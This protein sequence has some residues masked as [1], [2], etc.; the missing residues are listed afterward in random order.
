MSD[1][2]LPNENSDYSLPGRADESDAAYFVSPVETKPKSRIL[3]LAVVAFILVSAGVFSYYFVNQNEINS[4]IMDNTSFKTAEQ[5]MAIKYNVGQLGSN[6]A[7]AAIAVFV[8]GDKINF[9]LP[10]F[11]LQSKY[12][13]F[14]NHN[15]YQIHKH[16]TGVPLDMLFSS[17]EIEVSQNCIVLGTND[18]IS[19]EAFCADEKNS[20][21]FMVNGKTMSDILSYE[22]NH[23]DRI[24]I[25]FGSDKLH[26]EQ[27]RYLA[28][29]D[30]HDVPEKR[31][32]GS[33]RDI[34]I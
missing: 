7:H 24:L 22:I 17:F 15:P 28:S 4:Q 21:V 19:D 25:S 9:G 33:D 34:S 10:Q 14:E 23:N 26:S 27:L 31:S 12:I 2:A 8:E 32:Y 6:H 3:M 11:Q 16:A 20:L 13:H 5:K 29:L 1:S 18:A 30:V